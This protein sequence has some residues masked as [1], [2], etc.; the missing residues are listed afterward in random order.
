M[1]IPTQTLAGT[2]AICDQILPWKGYPENG[3]GRIMVLLKSEVTVI[4]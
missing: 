3:M 2:P 1:Q 4:I